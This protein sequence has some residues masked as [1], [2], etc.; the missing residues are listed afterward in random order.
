MINRWICSMSDSRASRRAWCMGPSSQAGLTAN[1]RGS[2]SLPSVMTS[3]ESGSVWAAGAG[4]RHVL[5]LDVGDRASG[6]RGVN[7]LALAGVD[8]DV[9]DP[10]VEEDQIALAQ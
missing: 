1:G 5:D 7:D 6:T 8:P 9:A 4:V 2:P 3:D 10:G